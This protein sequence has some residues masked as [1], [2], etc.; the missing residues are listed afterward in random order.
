MFGENK[1]ES[2]VISKRLIQDKFPLDDRT[3]TNFIAPI[4]KPF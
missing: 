4:K 2:L 1:T 3:D